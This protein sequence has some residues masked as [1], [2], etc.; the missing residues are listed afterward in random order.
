M[1]QY[2]FMTVRFEPGLG[3]RLKG[4]DFGD[5]FLAVLNEH[6]KDG[7]DLKTIIRESG[8]QT[9]LIFGRESHLSAKK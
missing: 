2:E 6:G 3:K 8:L 1:K 7:W 4:D 5:S 9:L